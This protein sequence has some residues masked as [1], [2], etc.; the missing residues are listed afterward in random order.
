MQ[1]SDYDK[2]LELQCRMEINRII[3]Y[4]GMHSHV[5]IVHNGRREYIQE[6]GEQACRRLHETG[7][8]TI[9]NA[10]LDQIKSN[11]TNHRSATLA[12][13]TTV[14][15]K[16]SGAQYTDGYGS[17]DNVVVQATVK[18][19]LRSF[20]FSIK[21]TTGHVIMPSGT[22]C[23]VFSRFC[24]DADGSET[25]WLPMPIDNCHFDRYDILYEGVATK[26]S[27]RINQSIPTVY[28]VTTQE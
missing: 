16:C 13:S 7:T 25:Y 26:L 23:K 8:L 17:W 6:I 22:H 5:S 11:A 20:E 19:T 2:T 21:R 15:E 3:N 12:G 1:L 9:G 18:I 4:C 28:T 27:P 14:D 24:I 10:V